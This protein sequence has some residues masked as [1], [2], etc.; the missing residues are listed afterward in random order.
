MK[1]AT[2]SETTLQQRQ[3]LLQEFLT[4]RI[5][6]WVAG[7]IALDIK[8]KAANEAAQ[9][10]LRYLLRELEVRASKL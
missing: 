1:R 5:D 7:Q 8:P 4:T 3:I 10:V 6:A 2:Q 9:T